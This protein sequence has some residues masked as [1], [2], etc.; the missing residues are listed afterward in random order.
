[1]KQRN[2]FVSL[3]L[4]ALFGSA[5]A[6]PG[7]TECRITT[8]VDSPA[9]TF[10]KLPIILSNPTTVFAFAASSYRNSLCPKPQLVTREEAQAMVDRA[11]AQQL[12]RLSKRDGHVLVVEKH[13]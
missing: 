1:M 4:V 10:V 3:V 13:K 8:A 12:E 5:N 2:I 7:E 11:V 9:A 6:G